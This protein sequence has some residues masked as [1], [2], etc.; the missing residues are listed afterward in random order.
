MALTDAQNGQRKEFIKKIIEKKHRISSSGKEGQTMGKEE[1]KKGDVIDVNFGNKPTKQPEKKPTPLHV[2]DFASKGVSPGQQKANLQKLRMLNNKRTAKNYNIGQYGKAPGQETFHV[3]EEHN[4]PPPAMTYGEAAGHIAN[5]QKENH[6]LK[7]GIANMDREFDTPSVDTLHDKID[8]IHKRIQDFNTKSDNLKKSDPWSSGQPEADKRDA[9]RS[10]IPT[11]APKAK[12]ESHPRGI[13]ISFDN[14]PAAPTAPKA[15]ALKKM[16][17]SPAAPPA[18]KKTNWVAKHQ[19]KWYKVTNIVDN[20]KPM[21][22]GGG[23]MYH[24]EGVPHP[25]HAQ[26]IEDLEI[27]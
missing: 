8:R 9:Q 11:T 6:A 22:Q 17:P 16:E 3:V 23:N 19:G 15:P 4:N 18:Q 26:H 25:V 20:K 21:N 2:A 14:P 24:L 5:A 1:L 12:P 7:Q 27:G 13:E 10:R